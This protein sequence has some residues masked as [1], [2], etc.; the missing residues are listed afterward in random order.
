MTKL[1]VAQ[2]KKDLEQYFTDCDP[3]LDT[4]DIVVHGTLPNG[5]R[6]PVGEIKTVPTKTKQKPYTIS[7]V[8]RAIGLTTSQFKKLTNNSKDK[9]LPKLSPAVKKLLVEALQKVEEYAEKQLYSGKATGAQFA[10]KNIG[11]WRDRFEHD[12]PGLNQAVAEL[13]G[14]IAK[15]LKS[16]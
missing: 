2:T 11:E 4:V 13:E 9:S 7:G 1:T 10:L 6:N 15:A 8:A 12:N 16:K 14:S 3:H 5:K